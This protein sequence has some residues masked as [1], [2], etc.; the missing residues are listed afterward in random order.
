L[1]KTTKTSEAAA[2]YLQI[3]FSQEMNM[4]LNNIK[5]TGLLAATVLTF[6]SFSAYAEEIK[7]EN[8]I[9]KDQVEGRVDEAKGKVKEITGK[10]LDDKGMEIEGN[11]QKNVGKAQAGFGDLKQDLKKDIKDNK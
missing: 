6:Y 11:I 5:L 9:N 8:N 2:R 7:V 10:I 4:K 1:R 3:P